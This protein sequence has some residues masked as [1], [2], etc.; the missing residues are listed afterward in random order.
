MP[1]KQSIR[2][3][4]QACLDFWTAL[5]CKEEKSEVPVAD[6]EAAMKKLFPS[7]EDW[8]LK[9]II[10]HAITEKPGKPTVSVEEFDHFVR[11]FLP[12][13][14]CLTVALTALIDKQTKF[15]FPWFHGFQ[16]PEF[17]PNDVKQFYVRLSTNTQPNQAQDGE[18]DII[19]AHCLVLHYKK[20]KNGKA[21]VAV[22]LIN[23]QKAD[24]RYQ[25]R[26]SSDDRCY[27]NFAELVKVRM[28]D[29]G[30]A[31]FP[32]G[33]QPGVPTTAVA[34]QPAVANPG[35]MYHSQLTIEEKPLE[36]KDAAPG[37]AAP[38]KCAGD[39]CTN[40]A[41]NWCKDCE[42]AYCGDACFGKDHSKGTLVKHKLGPLSDRKK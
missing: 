33:I 6:F 26:R 14:E 31:A 4:S 28:T 23:R 38:T 15:F 29:E 8:A 12:W 10:A 22:R 2:L 32:S 7:V 27:D 16:K 1:P 24:G 20:L 42:L 37:A 41:K 13:E 21:N 35:M 34:P 11:R 19:P 9:L 18:K 3:K 30:Y 25:F 17:P 36:K 5:C 39:N 40:P